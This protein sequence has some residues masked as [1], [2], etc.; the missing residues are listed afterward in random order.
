MQ[1][2]KDREESCDMLFSGRSTAVW[3]QTHSSCGHLHKI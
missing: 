3:S 2:L 1:E